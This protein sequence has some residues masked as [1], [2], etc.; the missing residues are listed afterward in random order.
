MC[1]D[2]GAR[3]PEFERQIAKVEEELGQVLEGLVVY[4]FEEEVEVLDEVFCFAFYEV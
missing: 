2:D 4:S 1:F 3:F